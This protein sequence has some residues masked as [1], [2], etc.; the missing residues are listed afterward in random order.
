MV[1]HSLLQLFPS[2]FLPVICWRPS[3][4]G[5]LKIMATSSERSHRHCYTQCPQACSRLLP[6]HTSARDSWTL[7]GESGSVS[8]GVTPP[9]F[10]V[11]VRTSLCL[12]PPRVYFPTLYKFWQLYGGVNGDLLQE[13]LCHTQVCCTQSPC[14]C[15]RP[16]L[17]R[18][19]TGDTQTQFCLSLCGFS[20]SSCTQG[21]FEPSERLWRKWGLIL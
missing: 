19:S 21:L 3:Y 15:G 18:T 2:P 8:C 6:T 7:M 20:G 14:P 1:C 12:C 9:F 4:G 10:W 5:P 17:T 13:G 16:L 11:L